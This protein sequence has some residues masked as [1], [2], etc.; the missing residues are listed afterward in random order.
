VF[1]FCENAF[2][3]EKSIDIL[4]TVTFISFPKIQMSGTV[5][6]IGHVSQFSTSFVV[7]AVYW[8]G[9]ETVGISSL[10]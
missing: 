8:S 1:L 2:D 6:G 3:R 10:T 9:G 5:R 7:K 4:T